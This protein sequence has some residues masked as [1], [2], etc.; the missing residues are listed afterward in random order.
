LGRCLGSLELS[1]QT[2]WLECCGWNNKQH[3][4]RIR[5]RYVQQ[6]WPAGEPTILFRTVPLGHTRYR[7]IG[8]YQTPDPVAHWHDKGSREG[9][10]YVNGTKIRQCDSVHTLSISR[11]LVL[12]LSSCSIFLHKLCV[13]H[14]CLLGS[15]CSPNHPWK[16]ESLF[17]RTVIK[18]YTNN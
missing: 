9:R 4:T 13:F 11:F 5:G 2:S 10:K 15:Y 16:E 6:V 8:S 12:S 17:F 14:V 1:S 18:G 7:G 3:G